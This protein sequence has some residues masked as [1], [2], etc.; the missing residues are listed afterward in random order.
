MKY[1]LPIE[2][3]MNS[4]SL[5]IVDTIANYAIKI[6]A[7]PGNQILCAKDGIVFYHKAFGHHTYDSIKSVKHNDIYDIAS[8]TKIAST[9]IGLMKLDDNR[10]FDV[11]LKLSDILCYLDT[12]DK[13]DLYIKDIL[14]HQAGL[15]SWIPFYR[16]TIE[17]DSIYN[18]LY[19]KSFS[20]SFNIKLHDSLY[21]LS[22]YRDS[23]FQAIIDSSLRDTNDYLY[24]DLGFYLLKEGIEEIAE[25]K[26][27]P[28]LQK[29]FY[30]PLGMYNTAFNP[31]NSFPLNQIIPS[32]NDTIF[33]K[34]VI[35]GYVNDPG[36]AMLGGVCGHAGLFSTSN[37]L[38]KLM[39][40]LLNNGEYGG[41]Q[42]LRSKTIKTYTTCIDC[43][44]NRRGLGFDKPELNPDKEGPV[45]KGIS[46]DSYG[47]SGFTGTLT[48]ADPETQI[49]YVFL[50]N[51]TY[52]NSS[53]SIL[54]KKNIRTDILKAFYNA[55]IV[56]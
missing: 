22:T 33:R 45:F 24:S 30:Q 14:S 32:E 25:E 49:I 35:Q 42:Y 34:Q 18:I 10:K 27:D 39:Q 9:S 5:Q 41:A 17:N 50:S 54:V 23:I 4:D 28:F 16:R 56:E 2:V 31:I 52:P 47:H 6:G 53:N 51:R 29:E 43:E 46:G 20:D 44:R 48:W 11:E 55:M 40:M 26:F 38:A 12:T 15:K 13:Q 36:A 1:G 37:D 3:G 21:L 7:T 19:S 8:I